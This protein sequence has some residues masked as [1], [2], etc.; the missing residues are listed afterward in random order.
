MTMLDKIG[1]ASVSSG[2]IAALWSGITCAIDYEQS[3]VKQPALQA[4]VNQNQMNM[5]A[6]E[7][8]ELRRRLFELDLIEKPTKLQKAMRE[9]YQADLNELDKRKAR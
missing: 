2:L 6:M 4:I 8:R 7:R 5:D 3:L 1:V 9:Q